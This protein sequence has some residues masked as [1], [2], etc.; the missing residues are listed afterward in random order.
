MKSYLFLALIKLHLLMQNFQPFSMEILSE[1]SI[2]SRLNVPSTS[3]ELSI[4]ITPIVM[5]ECILLNLILRSINFRVL[6]THNF[7]KPKRYHANLHN[8]QNSLERS[9]ETSA[10]V[11][12][13]HN[14]PTLLIFLSIPGC[15]LIT[16]LELPISGRFFSV[17]YSDNENY[18]AIYMKE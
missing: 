16:V 17:F 18:G 6:T 3:N 4:S 10:N 9:L 11:S 12:V 13:I 8:F 15:G 1:K 5:H 14:L 2:N 7:R